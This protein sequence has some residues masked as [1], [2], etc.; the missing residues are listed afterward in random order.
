MG[1]IP[2]QILYV[3]GDYN[4]DLNRFILNYFEIIADECKK[5]NLNFIYLPKINEWISDQSSWKFL[6][7]YFYP[8]MRSKIKSL[9]IRDLH[10][11][12]AEIAPSLQDNICQYF[13]ALGYRDEIRPGLLRLVNESETEG[14]T[15]E[16]FFFDSNLIKKR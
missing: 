13:E 7:S 16:Y 3:E 5:I 9:S 15:F 4:D 8:S 12:V 10:S 2:S 1:F 14:C 6:A 11:S